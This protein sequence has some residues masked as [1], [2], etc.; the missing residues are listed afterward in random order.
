[1]FI[2]ADELGAFR[3]LDGMTPIA[4]LG[5]G[6]SRFIERLWRHD[7]VVIDAMPRVL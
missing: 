7:L 1:M 5:P 4:T 6:A 3:S 2:D